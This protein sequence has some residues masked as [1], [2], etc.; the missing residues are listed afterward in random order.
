MDGRKIL[1]AIFALLIIALTT[2]LF[3]GTRAY[4]KNYNLGI[5]HFQKSDYSRALGFFRRA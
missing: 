5:R 1:I 4:Y 2:A 3:H